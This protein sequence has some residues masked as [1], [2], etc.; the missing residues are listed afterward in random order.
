MTSHVGADTHFSLCRRCEMEG[1]IETGYRVD[2]AKRHMNPCGE[3]LQSINRQKAELVLN[4]P[5]F[6]DQTPRSPCFRMVASLSGILTSKVRLGEWRTWG[7]KRQPSRYPSV[8]GRTIQSIDF[9]PKSGYK[10]DDYPKMR[11]V[12]D[13]RTALRMAGGLTFAILII[14]TSV[15]QNSVMGKYNGPG[16]Y[17]PSTSP[18]NIPHQQITPAPPNRD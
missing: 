17:A 12:N 14:L 6:V 5:K 18:G 7:R 11:T 16:A 1:G 8:S 3:L 13:G 15:S 9:A 2:L 4:G 10:Q